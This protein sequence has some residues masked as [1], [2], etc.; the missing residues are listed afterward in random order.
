M[1]GRHSFHKVN[2]NSTGLPELSA[3][4]IVL[5]IVILQ[6]ADCKADC[7]VECLSCIQHL[8]TYEIACAY[9]VLIKF[10]VPFTKGC[11]T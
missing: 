8:W 3:I 11:N 1:T 2:D 5:D 9:T 6:K 7:C 4:S 10:L